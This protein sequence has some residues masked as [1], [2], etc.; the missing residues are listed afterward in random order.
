MNPKIVTLRRR[1]GQ[2][3]LAMLCAVTTGPAD[4]F[5]DVWV[6]APAVAHAVALSPSLP[7]STAPLPAD[8]LDSLV[9]PIA[10]YPDPL[11]AQTLAASTYP[12]EIAALQDWLR[13]HTHLNGRELAT[14]IAKLPWDPSVQA[15]AALPEVVDLLADNYEW[16]TDLGN[17]FIKQESDVMDAVQR[18]RQRAESTGNLQS[19]EQQVVKKTVIENNPVIVIEPANPQVVYVPSYNPMMVFGPP[20][21]PFPRVYSRGRSNAGL[22]FGTGVAMGS[23]WGSGGGWGWHPGWGRR[24][25]IT[26]NRNN[27]FVRNSAFYRNTNVNTWRHNSGRRGSIAN[28]N[29][30]GAVGT[31]GRVSGSGAVGTSGRI[32]GRDRS[33]LSARSHNRSINRANRS[34]HRAGVSRSR[35]GA[36]R[37]TGGRRR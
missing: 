7:D 9:A 5:A 37:R 3:M 12:Q 20:A 28:R 18:M 29:R 8:Q 27:Y 30:V 35:T 10:L 1:G 13:M 17:A 31:R 26:V 15:M 33:R 11:L 21:Y 4:A 36:T 23:F 24:N 34:S 19:T 16:T 14:A 32:S 2:H 6:S 22:A 25:R